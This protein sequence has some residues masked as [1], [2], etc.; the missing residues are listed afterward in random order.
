MFTLQFS[1]L[2]LNAPL[3]ESS[4]YDRLEF[5]RIAKFRNV[6]S[7]EMVRREILHANLTALSEIIAS[8][9]YLDS[10]KLEVRRL[11]AQADFGML[12]WPCYR[13]LDVAIGGLLL[14]WLARVSGRIFRFHHLRLCDGF[15]RHLKRCENI[16]VR[17]YDWCG[18][19]NSPAP[20]LRTNSVQAS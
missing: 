14:L 11:N 6:S 13:P 20:N 2:G 1:Y 7:Y 9:V 5:A 16:A 18:R 15:Q 12:N 10:N 8:F 19:W 4:F 17:N 3:I